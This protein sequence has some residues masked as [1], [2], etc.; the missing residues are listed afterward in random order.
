M[1]QFGPSRVG[2]FVNPRKHFT[3]RGTILR[4]EMRS[5]G[6]WIFKRYFDVIVFEVDREEFEAARQA[7]GGFP[8]ATLDGVR[9]VALKS[10]IRYHCPM[11]CG[12]TKDL[13]VGSSVKVNFGYADLGSQQLLEEAPLCISDIKCCPDPGYRSSEG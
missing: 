3:V 5:E 7:L 13:P 6:F 8:V 12:K 10:E 9:E 2:P 1:S 4:H 11:E